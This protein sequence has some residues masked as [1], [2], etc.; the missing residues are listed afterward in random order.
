M[1]N[2]GRPLIDWPRSQRTKIPP[3]TRPIDPWR[4]RPYDAA[5]ECS[6]RADAM[7]AALTQ[8]ARGGT[9]VLSGT[10]MKRPRFDPN[11]IILNELVVTGSVEYTPDD[12]DRCIELLASDV[13][14]TKLLIEPADV[15][16]SDLQRAMERLAAGELPGKVLVVPDE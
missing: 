12:F 6:G 14:P 1:G 5:F 16:L 8:L 7:Q 9:L 11:R 10:G 4:P 2:D 13:L 3:D 15:P